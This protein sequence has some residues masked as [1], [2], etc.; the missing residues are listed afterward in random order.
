MNP[1]FLRMRSDKTYSLTDCISFVVMLDR[2]IAQALT[3]DSHFV[4]AGFQKLP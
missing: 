3:F 2:E 4:Q 1:V